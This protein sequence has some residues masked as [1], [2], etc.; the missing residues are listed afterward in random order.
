MNKTNNPRSKEINLVEYQ[1][2]FLNEYNLP[3]TDEEII[4]KPIILQPYNLGEDLK[5]ILI[6]HHFL[7]NNFAKING[8]TLDKKITESI[9]VKLTPIAK[10]IQWIPLRSLAKADLE[11]VNIPEIISNNILE[12]IKP[13]GLNYERLLADYLKGGYKKYFTLLKMFCVF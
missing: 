12:L 6:N 3:L 8:N 11:Q 7:F 1:I 13:P 9:T 5:T 10:Y 2:N 4:P